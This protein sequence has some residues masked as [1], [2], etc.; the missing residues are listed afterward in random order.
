MALFFMSG[1]IVV[2]GNENPKSAGG[3]GEQTN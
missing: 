2:G 3:F 1:G